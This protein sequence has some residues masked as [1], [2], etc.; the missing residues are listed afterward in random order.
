MVWYGFRA[1]VR[2]SHLIKMPDAS[3]NISADTILPINGKKGGRS[4]LSEAKR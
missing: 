3:K 4:P 1:I 2:P